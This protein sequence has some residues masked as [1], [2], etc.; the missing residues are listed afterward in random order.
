MVLPDS[1]NARADVRHPFA[2]G[3]FRRAAAAA[4]APPRRRPWRF[5]ALLPP[6]TEAER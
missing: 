4:P 1:R 3:T 6:P 5:A 2:S